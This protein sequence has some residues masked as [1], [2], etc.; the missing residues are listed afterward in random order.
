V[1]AATAT[2][3]VPV[4]ASGSDGGDDGSIFRVG[5]FG[6]VVP[7]QRGRAFSMDDRAGAV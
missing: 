4:A 6:D 3:H 5:S 1:A 7:V 2:L